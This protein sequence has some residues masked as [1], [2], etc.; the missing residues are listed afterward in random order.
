MDQLNEHG[1]EEIEAIKNSMKLTTT[2]R[3]SQKCEQIKHL[4]IAKNKAYGNSALDPLRIF[5]RADTIEQLNVRI[6]DKISRLMRGKDT[7]NVPEDT[8]M[9]LIGYLILRAIAI[10]TK[11]E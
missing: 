2:D 10:E 3:I 8:E 6:D 5:S 1:K 11:G 9:D 7:E 4:L